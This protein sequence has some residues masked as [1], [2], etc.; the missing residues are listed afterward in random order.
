MAIRIEPGRIGD[1]H[2]NTGSWARTNDTY[3]RI[4]TT[5]P[6][7]VWEWIG[8]WPKPCNAKLG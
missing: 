1:Y 2:F 5:V 4:R 8:T 7:T 3:V 6:A